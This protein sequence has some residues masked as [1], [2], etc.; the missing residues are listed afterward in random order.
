MGM[1]RIQSKSMRDL[2][3]G[4]FPS[5]AT[6]HSSEKTTDCNND[7]VLQGITNLQKDL[8]EVKGDINSIK[9]DVAE[10]KGDIKVI[11]SRLDT[12]NKTVDKNSDRVNTISK[13]AYLIFGG[14]IVLVFIATSI[15]AIINLFK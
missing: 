15:I 12:L 1:A 4:K 5:V 7:L 9:I 2:K 13:T 10:T 6:K 14:A 3:L 11:D 8:G